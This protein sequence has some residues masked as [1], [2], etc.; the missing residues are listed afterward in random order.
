MSDEKDTQSAAAD[1]PNE[2]AAKPSLETDKAKAEADKPSAEAAKSSS[3]AG[4]PTAG[5]GKPSAAAAKPSPQACIS[6][7]L[8]KRTK[9]ERILLGALVVVVFGFI[10]ALFHSFEVMQQAQNPYSQS[11]GAAKPIR[12][13]SESELEKDE[14]KFAPK[15]VAP[16]SK[17]AVAAHDR[18]YAP[19]TKV[20]SKPGA[21]PKPSKAK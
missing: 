7:F 15:I 5:A 18:L 16:V 8:A 21:A 1:K 4:S 2:E 3:E 20:N 19:N 17:E 14:A 11:A 6:S 12:P 9:A 13:A 10:Y